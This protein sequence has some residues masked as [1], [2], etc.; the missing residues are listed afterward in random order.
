MSPHDIPF[1]EV[2]FA[3]VRS[4]ACKLG[5][6]KPDYEYTLDGSHRYLRRK[7]AILYSVQ[8]YSPGSK[9]HHNSGVEN[10]GG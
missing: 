4:H 2:L 10:I 7:K 8:Q 5:Q 9:I 1:F 6:R 3:C